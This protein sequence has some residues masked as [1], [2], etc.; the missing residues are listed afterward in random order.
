MTRY[1]CVRCLLPEADEDALPSVLAPF[2]VLGTLVEGAGTA[3]VLVR[4][5][6]ASG[7]ERAAEEVARALDASG[8]RDAARE[9]VEEEDWL[10]GYRASARPFA[11]G[12]LWWLDPQPGDPTPA[13]AG[14]FRLAIEPR[15]AFGSG[16]HESTQLVLL[17]LEEVFSAGGSTALGSV[18]DVGTGSGILA[19]AADRLGSPWVLGVDLDQEAVWVARQTARQQGWTARPRFGVGSLSAL[20][21]A[22][23]HLVLCNMISASFL[24]LLG[25]LRRVLER[26]G[27]IVLSGILEQEQEAV[28]GEVAAAGLRVVAERRLGEWLCLRARG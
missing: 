14:R 5:Y 12:S 27:E 23:F 20:G 2:P 8:G 25:D 9:W 15:T 18:L 22:S 11:V 26:G 3:A 7:E 16:S 13:P 24:P 21:R 1:R 17:A 10:A 6:L 19:L 4:I 28:W